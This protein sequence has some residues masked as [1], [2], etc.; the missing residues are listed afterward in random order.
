VRSLSKI[1]HTLARLLRTTDAGDGSFSDAQFNA[2]QL[3]GTAAGVYNDDELV[4]RL[5]AINRRLDVSNFDRPSAG[6]LI[7]NDS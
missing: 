4:V 7:L 1:A 6:S 2:A 5:S 3:I